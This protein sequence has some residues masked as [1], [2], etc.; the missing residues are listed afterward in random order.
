MHAWCVVSVFLQVVNVFIQG[1]GV[2]SL[3]NFSMKIIF[4]IVLL[5]TQGVQYL[6]SCKMENSWLR[7]VEFRSCANILGKFLLEAVGI[8][9]LFRCSLAHML[10]TVCFTS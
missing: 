1:G 2:L 5:C 6:F 8:Q 10:W 9:S 4:V 3:C 7:Q